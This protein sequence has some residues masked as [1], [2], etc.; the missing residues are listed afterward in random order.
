LSIA[1]G[2]HAM[3]VAMPAAQ[4]KAVATLAIRISQGGD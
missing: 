1:V 4:N 2:T 3:N